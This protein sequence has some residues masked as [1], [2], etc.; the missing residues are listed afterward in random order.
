M[1]EE[2]KDRFATNWLQAFDSYVDG[3]W[4]SCREAV[5]KCLKDHEKDG[6]CQTMLRTIK[7]DQAPAGWKGYRAL[8]D[9]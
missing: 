3:A 9:K 1:T 8:T 4:D 6:P 7:N 5:G 2:A